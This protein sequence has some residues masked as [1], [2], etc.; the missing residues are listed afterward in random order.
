MYNEEKLVI[1]IFRK[2]LMKNIVLR[3]VYVVD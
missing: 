2:K 3:N 1:E